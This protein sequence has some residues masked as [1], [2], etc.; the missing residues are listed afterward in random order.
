MAQNVGKLIKQFGAGTGLSDTD[1][2][3][4]EQMAGGQISLDEKSMR[5]ILDISDRAARNV[6]LAHNKRVEG[7]QSKTGL[8]V[9]MPPTTAAAV[10]SAG[11][12]SVTTPDGKVFS[13]PTPEAAAQFKKAAGIP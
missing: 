5:K 1:R 6:I 7:V 11:G 4:A 9:E 12:T 13:F 10:N 2:K 3:F 8:T